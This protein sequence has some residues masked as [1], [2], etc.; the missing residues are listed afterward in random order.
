MIR[1]PL[2][3]GMNQT[4]FKNDRLL[5]TQLDQFGGNVV[6]VRQRSIGFGG[7]DLSSPVGRTIQVITALISPDSIDTK[8]A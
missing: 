7:V 4:Y 8:C 1:T 2:S 6:D 5:V 3:D